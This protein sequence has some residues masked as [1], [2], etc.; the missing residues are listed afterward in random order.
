MSVKYTLQEKGNPQRP[1][2]PKKWYAIAKSSGE[3]TLRQLSCEIA[4]KS[5][6]VSEADVMDGL[7]VFAK[8]LIRHLD[9]GEIVRLGDF[10][11]FQICMGSVGAE[12]SEK[13]DPKMIRNPKI[14]FRPGNDLKNLIQ[15][16]KFE[17]Y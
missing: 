9:N 4:E 5:A 14:L 17:K 8:A 11:S 15:N 13:F 16:L 2:A 12:T 10:G 3:V 7:N 1:A 6:T